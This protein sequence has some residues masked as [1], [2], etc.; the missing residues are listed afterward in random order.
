MEHPTRILHAA[1]LAGLPLEAALAE[2]RSTGATPVEAIKAIREVQ[3]CSLG[4]AKQVFGASPAWASA[5]QAGEAL[6]EQVQSVLS[7]GAK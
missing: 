2:L 3:G 5:V 1:L 6:H 7:K 4:E